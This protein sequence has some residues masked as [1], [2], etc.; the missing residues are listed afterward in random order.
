MSH[1]VVV[2]LFLLAGMTFVYVVAI[3]HTAMH[4][5]PSPKAQPSDHRE[6]DS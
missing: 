3:R 5:D 2:S 6:L 4:H 1:Q